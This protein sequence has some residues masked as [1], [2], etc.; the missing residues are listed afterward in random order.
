LVEKLDNK[1]IKA[2]FAYNEDGLLVERLRDIGVETFKIN[3]RNPFD[4]KAAW[5]LGRLCK[6]LGIELIHT[7]FLRENYIA[8]LIQVSKSIDAIIV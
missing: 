5:E 1:K 6:K 7:Q 8:I 3:M 2:Y 4:I